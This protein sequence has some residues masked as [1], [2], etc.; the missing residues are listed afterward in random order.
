[1]MYDE[2]AAAV[3]SAEFS[4]RGAFHPD[5][6]DDVPELTSGVPVRTLMLVGNVGPHV[7]RRFSRERDPERDSLDDWSRD[8]LSAIAEKIGGQPIFPFAK[9]P[10]PFQRWSQHAE[11]CRPSPIGI[12]IHPVYGLWH[13]YRGALAFGERI[14]LPRPMP[15]PHPCLSCPDRR[16]LATCPVGAFSAGRYD[17]AKCARHLATRAGRD[18]MELGCRARHACHVGRPYVYEPAQAG[19]HMRA[20]L[21]QRRTDGLV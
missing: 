19:F 8:C 20:F 14:E 12:Y 17:L 6:G 5:A 16:C 10:L 18:C 15:R 13:G 9:P 21:R 4:V 3:A 11:D 2:I 7:W 1:M